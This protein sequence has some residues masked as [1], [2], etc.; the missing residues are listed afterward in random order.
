VGGFVIGA[1]LVLLIG[2]TSAVLWVV[3]PFAV[4]IAA[5]AP[6]TAP[7]AVGQ[8]AFTVT[9]VILFNL[10]VPTGW[11]VG[12]L[13]IIDVA[14]GCA[15]S[16]L[17]GTCFWPRGVSSVVG[18]DLADA[19][20]SGARYLSRAVECLCVIVDGPPDGAV[21]AVTAGLRLDAALRGFL[22][23]QGSKRIPKVELWRLVGGA[24]RLR[25]T[26]H[27]LAGLPHH[28]SQEVIAAQQAIAPRAKILTAFYEQL[29]EEV[30]RPH[31]GRLPSLQA[32]TFDQVATAPSTWHAVW[33][34]E[35]MR[36]L[37]D[38][39]AELVAP[40]KH[41]ADVRRRPWWR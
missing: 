11:K 36:H 23:E 20:R 16:L 3:L 2:D 31:G 10:L 22:A 33:L 9:V 37:A 40:A 8:A 6:G 12:E 29:A 30:G 41:L 34:C 28:D 18:D 19:Y 24:L 38:H 7:F 35:H 4:L 14:L 17:V 26:A 21:S 13:R 25:L 5:Y 1:G 27:A 32:P 15:V 39:L